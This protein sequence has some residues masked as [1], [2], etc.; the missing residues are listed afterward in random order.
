[1]IPPAYRPTYSHG[2]PAGT[3]MGSMWL[4]FDIRQ[5]TDV[6]FCKLQHYF[7]CNQ[8]RDAPVVARGRRAAAAEWLAAWSGPNP[9]SPSRNLDECDGAGDNNLQPRG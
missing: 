6:S 2:H 3:L 5:V 4:R 1:M 7:L 8:R 9:T